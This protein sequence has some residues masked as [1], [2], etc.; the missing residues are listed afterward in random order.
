MRGARTSWV[1]SNG[2]RP[3]KARFSMTGS[4]EVLL[5]VREWVE[6]AES[7][8]IAAVHLLQLGEQGPLHVV[9][10]NAQQCVEKY[11]KAVLTW[12]AIAFAKTHDLEKVL[13]LV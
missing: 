13:L 11:F 8:L 6:K 7:D 9:C 4:D 5:V 3:T 12:K 10:F 1:R 2:R